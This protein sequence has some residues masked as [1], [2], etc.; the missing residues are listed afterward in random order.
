[1]KQALAG[2]HSSNWEVRK[3]TAK[4]LGQLLP[5]DEALTRLAELLGDD[6]IAVELEAA[7]VLARFGGRPGLFAILG[8]LGRRVDDPD[9]DYIAYRLQ[10]LQSNNKIPVL[11]HAREIL[12]QSPPPE[13]G[14]AIDQI[15]QRFGYLAP[16]D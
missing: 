1:M 8:E 13:V 10:E 5:A 7:E 3:G 11:Q 15:E 9:S 4:K 14:E 6:N 12:T 16:R 2:S